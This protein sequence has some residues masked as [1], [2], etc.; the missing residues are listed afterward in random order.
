[1][2]LAIGFS[3]GLHEVGHLLPA[4]K[5]GVRVPQYMIG[6]GKTLFSWRRGETEY[7][8]KAIPLGGYISMI[9]MYPPSN[10]EAGLRAST[11]GPFS[12]LVEDARATDYERLQPG[13]EN[14][15]FY[16]LPIYKRIIIMLGGP[17]M[18]LAIGVVC[19][20]VLILGFGSAQPTTTV[21]SMSECVKTVVAAQENAATCTDKDPQAPAALAGVQLNDT[22]VEFAGVRIDSWEQLTELI[23]AHANKEVSMTVLREGE[24]KQL[25][26]EPMLTARPLFNEVTGSY[27]TN[28]DGSYKTRDVG[29]IGVGPDTQLVPGTAGEVMPIV[30]EQLRSIYASVLR[31]PARVWDVAVVLA[32]NGER[33]PDGP[34]SVVG[35]GRIAGEVA[36][37]DQINLKEKAAT[38][39]SMI[40][41]LNLFLFA[42]NLIPLLPL[43]GGHVLGALWESVRR[44]FARLAGKPDP[45]A[46]D[47]ARLL[48]LTFV[49]AGSFMVMSLVL[50]VADIFKPVS[51]F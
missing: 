46:F 17:L 24:E 30:G 3:I 1:M 28:P 35:V 29:F 22:V 48:P 13:D 23:R 6:F 38:L 14:R 32:T 4:K 47:A 25:R 34:M 27:E 36:A 39:V 2:A 51:L 37:T 40:G 15:V 11:T 9:G 8:V 33:D 44:G 43:D 16:K 50:I 49:V 7:G 5:F 19:T 20:A 31:L 10:A 12:Q 26:I 41:T 45:G 18:N 42:F 21:A